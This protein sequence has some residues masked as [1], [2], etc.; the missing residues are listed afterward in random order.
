MPEYTYRCRSCDE[1]SCIRHSVSERLENCNKCLLTGSLERLPAGF[2]L[3]KADAV[4]N[5]RVG[6]IVDQSISEFK[7]DLANEK[8]KLKNNMWDS[9][10]E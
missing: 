1:V 8:E 3:I 4:E 5:S 6:T 9:N 7:Q 2:R 10:H